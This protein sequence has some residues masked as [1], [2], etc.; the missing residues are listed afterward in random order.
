MDRETGSD[1]EE[2]APTEHDNSE[3][4]DNSKEC[5]ENTLLNQINQNN[6]QIQQLSQIIQQIDFRSLPGEY[7]N[8]S[9]SK[10][11]KPL[12]CIVCIAY[13]HPPKKL[14]KPNTKTKYFNKKH[15]IDYFVLKAI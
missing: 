3:E 12:P 6:K 15:T 5:Q 4:Y 11:T 13:P 14:R 8:L 7:H 2:H 1:Q 10:I 9:K